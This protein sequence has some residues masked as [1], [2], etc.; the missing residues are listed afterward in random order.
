MITGRT[1]K[2]NRQESAEPLTDD[3]RAAASD[4]MLLNHIRA[5]SSRWAK[6]RWWID[7]DALASHLNE[8]MVVAI[9]NYDSSR[10]VKLRTYVCNRLGF[11]VRDYLREAGKDGMGGAGRSVRGGGLDV[12][13]ISIN[14]V[15]S[16]D[17]HRVVTLEGY[18]A[19]PDM[20]DPEHV[21]SR[22][23]AVAWLSGLSERSRSVIVGYVLDGKTMKQVG[24][25]HGM[26]ESRV[27]QLYARLMD[28]LREP[29]RR[30]LEAT[31]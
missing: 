3:Q 5:M 2:R 17:G 28:E 27:S 10:G 24:E 20:K 8:A 15:I 13:Q 18:I 30:R 23:E 19:A 6:G 9:R 25:E 29:V 26:S 16:S 14:T 1:H 21:Q 4:P 12:N 22:E 11:A 7:R 31:A